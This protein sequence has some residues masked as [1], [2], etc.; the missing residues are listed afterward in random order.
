MFYELLQELEV[1][2]L[3]LIQK[4]KFHLEALHGYH[5]MVNYLFLHLI[6]YK[7]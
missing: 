2:I 6:M 5:E 4:E 1:R 3:S 7:T